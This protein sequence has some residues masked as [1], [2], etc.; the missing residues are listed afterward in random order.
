MMAVTIRW[1]RF[2]AKTI[3]LCRHDLEALELVNIELTKK[4]RAPI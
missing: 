2:V 3:D 1:A 4:P